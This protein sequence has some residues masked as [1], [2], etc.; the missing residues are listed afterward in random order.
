MFSARGALRWRHA[1][2]TGIGD[3][4]LLRPHHS[5]ELA[6]RILES[7][8]THRAS[9]VELPASGSPPSRR[10]RGRVCPTRVS[11]GP[12]GPRPRYWVPASL[13][14]PG[15]SASAWAG[16]SSACRRGR[17][18]RVAGVVTATSTARRFCLRTRVGAALASTAAP[19]ARPHPGPQ[20][21]EQCI[22]FLAPAFSACARPARRQPAGGFR[23]RRR[24]QA[25]R[26]APSA[27]ATG[28]ASAS[29]ASRWSGASCRPSHAPCCHFSHHVAVSTDRAQRYMR[30]QLVSST[31][32]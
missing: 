27:S 32:R 8:L 30:S 26:S 7:V 10:S 29:G 9:H 25:G 31:F 6:V 1:I 5:A 16:A 21:A 14:G 4:N 20:H 12:R 28:P 18:R 24:R 22:S 3:G 15:G 19:P 17:R 11:P 2:G 13:L 23:S